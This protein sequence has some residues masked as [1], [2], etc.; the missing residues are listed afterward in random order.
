MQEVY[1]NLFVG[2]LEEYQATEK[3]EGS[4]V[5]HAA[6]EPYHRQFVGYTGKACEKDHP[7]YLRAIRGREIALNLV[8]APDSKYF[9]L[10]LIKQAVKDTLIF[11]ISNK[12][13]Y[14]HC[15]KWES[16]APWIAMIALLGL[17]VLSEDYNVAKRQF[18][19][20]YP[21]YNPGKGMNEFIE[22]NWEYFIG[23]F[24]EAPLPPLEEEVE[25]E[26]V[27]PEIPAELRAELGDIVAIDGQFVNGHTQEE[28]DENIRKQNEKLEAA[29]I[30]PNPSNE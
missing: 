3:L 7:E 18:L 25:P 12:A 14:I 5:L 8:D 2:S 16:R 10:W 19:S 28:L 15:N 1:H 9:D 22:K 29:W 11:L 6:K 24:S 21:D 20:I 4:Y 13:V 26:V 30:I 27:A 17:H 23:F